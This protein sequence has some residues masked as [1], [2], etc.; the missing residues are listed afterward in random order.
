MLPTNRRYDIDWLRVITIGL[1]LIYHIAIVF[2]PWGVLIGFIQSTESMVN[3]WTPMTLINVWRIPLLFFVSGMGVCFAI[4]KRNW[5]Q[6][7]MERTQ[8]IFLPFL[9]GALFIVPLHI[10]IWQKYYHQDFNYTPGEGHLWFLK[11][12]F[13][14]IVLLIPA[15][16]YLKNNKTNILNKALNFLFR[17]PLG[18]LVVIFFFVLEG[19]WVNP[20]AYEMYAMTW[21]GFFLGL[22]AFFFGFSFI[23]TGRTFWPMILKWRWILLVLAIAVYSLRFTLFD[24]KTPNYLMAIESC[25]WIF[26]IFGFAY[27]YLNHPSKV[28]RYLSEAAY[29]IYIIHMILLYLGSFLILPLDIPTELKFILLVVFTFVGC[30]AL[31]EFVIRR[32]YFLRPLFGLKRNKRAYPNERGLLNIEKTLTIR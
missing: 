17:N 15:F 26:A 30:F 22:I 13:V 16:F 20:M 25:L 19:V 32:V 21:H 14:Y 29:P 7:L 8:R 11:N 23:Q 4:R 6:L 31:Y 24:L 1:L 5:K 27:K 18:L 12:I 9:F 3:L 10:F 2:Q 28:L